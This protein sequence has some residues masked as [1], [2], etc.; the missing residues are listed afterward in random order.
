M[1]KPIDLYTIEK[2]EELKKSDASFVSTKQTD[3]NLRNE[4][5]KLSDD[6][7]LKYVKQAE[8]LYDNYTE[9]LVIWIGFDSW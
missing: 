5:N 2:T 9:V 3:L 4:F 8:L 7:L 1:F 6:K